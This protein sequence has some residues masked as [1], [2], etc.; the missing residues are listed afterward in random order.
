MKGF[1]ATLLW[2][3]LTLRTGV[4]GSSLDRWPLPALDGI[5]NTLLFLALRREA[6]YPLARD[7]RFAG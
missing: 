4:R 1:L 3:V 6:G 2:I 7:Y 5:K